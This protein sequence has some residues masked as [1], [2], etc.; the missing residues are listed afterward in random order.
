MKLELESPGFSAN[1]IDG[2]VIVKDL[3]HSRE[4]E[5]IVCLPDCK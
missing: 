2:Y 3:V 5:F 1:P 4:V